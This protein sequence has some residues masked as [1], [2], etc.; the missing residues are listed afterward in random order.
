VH[1]GRYTTNVQDQRA[2]G[3]EI[4]VQRNVSPVKP[5]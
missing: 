2:K 4:T 3:Q 5:L 1:D